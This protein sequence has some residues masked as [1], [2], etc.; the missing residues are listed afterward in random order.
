MRTCVSK[1]FWDDTFKKIPWLFKL[2]HIPTGCTQ[3]WKG[4]NDY[5]CNNEDGSPG[6]YVE[7]KSPSQRLHAAWV[8]LHSILEMTQLRSWR[9]VS[10]CRGQAGTGRKEEQ[11]SPKA[12]RNC[13]VSAWAP[14]HWSHQS[15]RVIQPQRTKHTHIPPQDTYDLPGQPCCWPVYTKSSQE[16]LRGENKM[17]QICF[18]SIVCTIQISHYYYFLLFVNFLIIFKR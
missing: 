2:N 9:T 1:R 3:R 8:H 18:R 11:G 4:T 6:N 12:W 10:G 5:T 17:T 14:Q 7:R 13:W 16:G 15:T